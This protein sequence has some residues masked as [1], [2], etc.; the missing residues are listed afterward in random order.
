M[1]YYPKP[2]EE[3]AFSKPTKATRELIIQAREELSP[4]D[5]NNVYAICRAIMPLAQKR[6]PGEGVANQLT[7]M[8]IP[9]SKDL[10]RKI[11]FFLV[12]ENDEF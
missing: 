9:K 4:A 2:C 6:Y 1:D 8:G 3:K 10:I 5:R 11:E 12:Y 7:R